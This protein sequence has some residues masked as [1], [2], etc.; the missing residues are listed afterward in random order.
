M[1]NIKSLKRAL[2]ADLAALMAA[3]VGS[4]TPRAIHISGGLPESN[5]QAF[6]NGEIIRPDHGESDAA[7]RSRVMLIARSKRCSV[8]IFGGLPTMPGCAPIPPRH[9]WK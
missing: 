2:L 4:F 1:Q 8:A 5:D 9:G 3:R 7:F 6:V